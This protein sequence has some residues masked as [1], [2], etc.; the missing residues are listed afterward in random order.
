VREPYPGRALE[1]LAKLGH[2]EE[3]ASLA[4]DINVDP[5]LRIRAASLLIR[6]GRLEEGKTILL[7]LANPTADMNNAVELYEEI[8]AVSGEFDDIVGLGAEDIQLA[9]ARVEQRKVA[10]RRKDDS[11]W[12]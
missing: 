8:G 7:E 11:I 5:F 2:V 10:R 3:I 4:R 12:S 9:G 1:A 6:F